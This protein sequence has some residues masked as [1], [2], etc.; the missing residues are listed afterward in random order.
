ME[1]PLALLRIVG[2]T[3]CDAH[4]MNYS[5]VFMLF[6]SIDA[7][8]SS[9]PDS[10]D[11]PEPL[12]LACTLEVDSGEDH[13]EL[14]RLEFDAVAFGG[15]GHLEGPGLESLVPDGQPVAIE[16]EDLDPISAAVD[17]EEEMAGQG[18]LAEALL[19]QA[20]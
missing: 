17:E 1:Q 12:A 15:A 4:D 14:R 5:D 13:G 7:D 11:V 6:K 18:V 9:F 2:E 8:I 3:W 16:V 20:R 10:A 19:D